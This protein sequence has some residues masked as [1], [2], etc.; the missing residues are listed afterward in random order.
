MKIW[1]CLLLALLLGPVAETIILAAN[2][3]HDEPWRP[4][5]SW[6]MAIGISLYYSV[7]KIDEVI[8]EWIIAPIIFIRGGVSG[9]VYMIL[10]VIMDTVIWAA[11]IYFGI[12]IFKKVSTRLRGGLI[13]SDWPTR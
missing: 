11:L 3:F 13:H 1:K 5:P 8:I 12:M 6:L 2:I 4:T 10:Y 9:S 7:G